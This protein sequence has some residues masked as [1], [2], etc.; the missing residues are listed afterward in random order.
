MLQFD[1]LADNVD[2]LTDGQV[3]RHQILLLVNPWQR[4]L[5]IPLH[6]HLKAPRASNG[7]AKRRRGPVCARDASPLSFL[8]LPVAYLLDTA[9]RGRDASG[10]WSLPNACSCLNALTGSFIVCRLRVIR[11]IKGHRLQLYPPVTSSALS[12]T[13]RRVAPRAVCLASDLS[14]EDG[15]KTM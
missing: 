8:P 12:V 7:G 5:A 4:T 15:W 9:H 13:R 6:N 11:T 14:E 2:K 10:G 1:S 3:T